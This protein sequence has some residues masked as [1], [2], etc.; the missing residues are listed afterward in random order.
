MQIHTEP[1]SMLEELSFPRRPGEKLHLF[2]RP[3]GHV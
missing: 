3:R 1:A 2:A